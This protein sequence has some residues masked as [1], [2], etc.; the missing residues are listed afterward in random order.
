MKIFL[1][2]CFLFSLSA[3]CTCNSHRESEK[4]TFTTIDKYIDE[5]CSLYLMYYFTGDYMYSIGTMD[6]CKNLTRDKY[7]ASYDTLLTN[8]LDKIL[9]KKDKIIFETTF[10][11]GNDSLFK[12]RLIWITENKFNAISRIVAKETNADEFTIELK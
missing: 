3:T 12:K 10:S 11:F 7:I 9:I 5:S 6:S 4:P 1:G 2:Y 8:N